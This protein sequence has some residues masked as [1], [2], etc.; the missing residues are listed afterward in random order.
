MYKTDQRQIELWANGSPENTYKVIEFVMCTANQRFAMVP[1]YLERKARKADKDGFSAMQ[2]DSLHALWQGRKLVYKTIQSKK[3]D[4]VALMRYLVSIPGLSI[5]KAG[6]T[7]Q[8]LIGKVGCFDVHNMRDATILAMLGVDKVDKNILKI[9]KHTTERTLLKKLEQY[10][11]MCAQ[12]GSAFL[13]DNWCATLAS[14]YK[15][16]NTFYPWQTPEQVSAFHVTA[17]IR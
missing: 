9:D 16:N 10:V 12:L 7:A 8:L 13:W 1:M 15:P 6:F 4:P 11:A 2:S 14:K 17:C 5:A 3:H